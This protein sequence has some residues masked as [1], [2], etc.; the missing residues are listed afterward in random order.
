MAEQLGLDGVFRPLPPVDGHKWTVTSGAA[1]VNRS[2]NQVFTGARFAKQQH[3]GFHLA[4]ARIIAASLEITGV[5]PTK[6][7]PSAAIAP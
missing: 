3:V 1:L 2:G 6:R 5:R 7:G 4:D